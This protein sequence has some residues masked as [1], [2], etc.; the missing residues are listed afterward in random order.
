MEGCE[1]GLSKLTPPTIAGLNHT[2][3][4]ERRAPRIGGPE[5][6][7]YYNFKESETDLDLPIRAPIPDYSNN[8]LISCFFYPQ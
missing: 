7:D 6:N 3:L 4:L 8:P 5:S 1:S 2:K